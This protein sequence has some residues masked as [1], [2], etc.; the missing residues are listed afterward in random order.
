MPAELLRAEWGSA[1]TPNEDL[2][3]HL[4]ETFHVSLDAL[5][6]RLHNVGL[7][8]AAGRDRVRAM[9]PLMSLVRNQAPQGEGMWLPTVLT[10]DTISAY[11]EGRIGA[12][13]LAALLSLDPD[14][15]LERLQASSE[16]ADAFDAVD[17][18][19]LA[20]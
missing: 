7:I 12:R 17:Q 15:M 11:A 19:L 4:L 13:W 20:V 9:R 14:E 10:G 16:E 18:E 3:G 6:F 2:I 5:A 8:N 1:V